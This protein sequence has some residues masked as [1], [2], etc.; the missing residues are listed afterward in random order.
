MSRTPAFLLAMVAW[1]VAMSSPAL[2]HAQLADEI[3]R[4]IEAQGDV[5]ITANDGTEINATAGLAENPDQGVPVK[6]GNTVLTKEYSTA[7]VRTSDGSLHRLQEITSMQFGSRAEPGE[8]KVLSLF[9]GMVYFFSRQSGREGDYRTDYVNAAVKGTEFVL[10]T[11]DQEG[12]RIHMIE[13][14]VE[15]TNTTGSVTV[16]S[17]F[18]SRVGV[19]GAVGN[20]EPIVRFGSEVEWF[21]YYPAILVVEDLPM[22]PP[23]GSALAE[24]IQAYRSGNLKDAV[25]LMQEV[26][27]GSQITMPGQ[28]IYLAALALSVGRVDKA[29]SFIAREVNAFPNEAEALRFLIS[30]MTGR[31]ATPSPAS[32]SSASLG[33]AYSYAAQA[34]GDLAAALA[35]VDSAERAAGT[36]NAMVLA[37][38]SE[39]LFSLGRYGEAEI[40]ATEAL[41]LAPQSVASK[42]RLGFLQSVSGDDPAAM[43]TFTEAL[44]MDSGYPDAWIGR[45]LMRI[46]NGQIEEGVRDIETAISLSPNN[47]SYRNYLARLFMDR[48]DWQRAETE[49]GLAVEL[50][51]D[52]PNTLLVS[53][54][55]AASR[56]ETASALRSLRKSIQNNDQR[57]VF[58]SPAI[59]T[60][61]DA[62]R[63]A[64][65]AE[66]FADAGL[67]LFAIREAT[68]ASSR[69]PGSFT[70]HK[71][72]AQAYANQEDP[73][74]S[75]LR[76]QSPAQAERLS[77]DIFSPARFGLMP[78]ATTP[79]NYNNLLSVKE[80]VYEAHLRGLLSYGFNAAFRWN[81]T[82]DK[83]S[84]AL[85]GEWDY[86][87]DLA[88]DW[89]FDRQA[90]EAGVKFD[91][92]DT[93][94]VTGI[95]RTNQR[96]DTH[97]S[98]SDEAYDEDF[99]SAL[100]ALRHQWSPEG[101]TVVYLQSVSFD[102]STENEGSALVTDANGDEV[103]GFLSG[104]INSKSKSDALQF[105]VQHRQTFQNYRLVGGV[106]LQDGDWATDFELTGSPDQRVEE[107]FDRKEAYL[108]NYFE[109]ND[110][111][112]LVAGA[113]ATRF[114]Y[115]AN[116]FTLPP[117]PA[118]K[119]VDRLLPKVGVYWDA[120]PN[121]TF[122]AAYLESLG[123]L[124]LED[125]YRLEP[126][127]VAGFL[128]GYRTLLAEDIDGTH[129]AL[130][131]EIIGI[132][133]THSDDSNF[134]LDIELNSRQ[135]TSDRGLGHLRNIPP[136]T[137]APWNS[138]T[139]FEEKT[140]AIQ[141][142]KIVG[143]STTLSLEYGYND[144]T[145]D[146][147]I[148][149]LAAQVKRDGELNSFGGR[150]L[151]RSP[152]GFFTSLDVIQY[153]QTLGETSFRDG[154]LVDASSQSGIDHL[155]A[156]L[157]AGWRSQSGSLRLAAGVKNL[158]DDNTEID[159]L[160]WTLP[161]YPERVFYLDGSWTF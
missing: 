15:L 38:K 119:T 100:I 87:E 25:N 67:P 97:P 160:T 13:G 52:D 19:N 73:S 54:L 80:E 98:G 61:D 132:G 70:A 156:N 42:T 133:L 127:Q 40:A 94:T 30:V 21:Y 32:G 4:V 138:F 9:K 153:C 146:S 83:S 65:M 5:R 79:N 57:S 120:T 159:P 1:V 3:G 62:L 102:L 69:D 36:P 110:T 123:G 16:P 149:T 158:F 129:P 66:L 39:L 85:S 74:A 131:F 152:S 154:L 43:E 89:N 18:Q 113:N 68:K 72:L 86:L 51:P 33:L 104:T 141:L 145:V 64:N 45:G 6:L 44:S 41:R 27:G 53:A 78:F 7:T 12:T 151:H 49:S 88:P 46:R 139:R 76:F 63:R 26:A 105:E 137:A 90:L 126:T 157:E 84:V 59:L 50:A 28:A 135:S 117:A 11:N 29:E 118:R 23:A 93:D 71:F 8:K 96:R 155:Q 47:A 128:Q 142:G 147:V 37:R 134:F 22:N 101:E 24:S 95:F 115:P 99:P 109:L 144:S 81:K 108:Y 136:L 91:L 75:T 56:N 111:L 48:S 2:L 14:E 116:T 122:R 143:K 125:G 35:Y 107:P 77:F 103:L 112:T 114:S 20:P 34:E 150:I 17:G 106:R 60:Q 124:A 140:A 161:L 31:E 121:T 82:F 92:S 130:E 55:Q 148:P 10:W 58:R